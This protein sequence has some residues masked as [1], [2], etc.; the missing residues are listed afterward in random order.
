M[1]K[2]PAATPKLPATPPAAPAA[3]AAAVAA[4]PYV[5]E[6]VGAPPER[7]RT[8]GDGVPN[9]L[10]AFMK[11]MPAPEGGAFASFF[12]PADQAPATVTDADERRKVAKANA[13]KTTNNIGTLK[14]KI[15]KADPTFNFTTREVEENGVLGVRVYRIAP[16]APAAV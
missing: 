6:V 10:V 2:T 11:D 3:P 14:R 15:A 4:V 1:A 7:T 9:P 13:R 8:F 16:E 12:I 5:I